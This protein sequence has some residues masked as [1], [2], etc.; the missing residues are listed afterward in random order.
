LLAVVDFDYLLIPLEN[1]I[2]S[3]DM[4][5]NPF[6][7]IYVTPDLSSDIRPNQIAFRLYKCKNDSRDFGASI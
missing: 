3:L 2:L 4:I 1:G 6:V 5:F 7:L